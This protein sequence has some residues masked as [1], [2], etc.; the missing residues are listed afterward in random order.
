MYRFIV[1]FTKRGSANIFCAMVHAVAKLDEKFDSFEMQKVDGNHEVY[2]FLS[3]DGN[4]QNV[5]SAFRETIHTLVPEGVS[6]LTPIR[7]DK[8]HS[9]WLPEDIQSEVDSIRENFDD[10][11]PVA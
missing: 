3:E 8:D 1:L 5:A 7:V 11:E 2:T 9:K 6:W 4:E 10:W